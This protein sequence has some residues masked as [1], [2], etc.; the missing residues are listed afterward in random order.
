MWSR[1]CG[2]PQ[3]LVKILILV[4][5]AV[6]LCCSP[7]DNL[8]KKDNL[9]K[10]CS[11]LSLL[12]LDGTLPV[13]SPND[14]LDLTVYCRSCYSGICNVIESW[15]LTS[16][17]L[18]RFFFIDWP[19]HCSW[20]PL[21]QKLP[22]PLKRCPKDAFKRS[23]L[24][25]P[26]FQFLSLSIWMEKYSSFL[27]GKSYCLQFVYTIDFSHRKVVLEVCKIHASNLQSTAMQIIL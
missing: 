21:S 5:K 3:K 10:G 16:S 9:A 22:Y 27:P 6:S 14:I 4:T 15:A 8:S 23:F 7:C 17:I 25:Q 1:P 12:V 20:L 24:G 2:W 19:I 13:L 11:F 26:K 18:F